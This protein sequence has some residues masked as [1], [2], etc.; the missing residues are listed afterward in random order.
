MATKPLTRPGL[1]SALRNFYPQLCTIQTNTP[2]AQDT[3]GAQ[4]TGW[5][6]KANHVGLACVLETRAGRELKLPDETFA[7]APYR[8]ALAG[9]YPTIAVKDRATVGSVTIDIL[10]VQTD[11]QGVATYLDGQLVTS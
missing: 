10:S 3:F 9:A 2:A 1:M 8:I 5:A 6:N 11:S 7:I 4:P